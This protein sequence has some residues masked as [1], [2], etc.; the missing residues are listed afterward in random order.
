MNNQE[1]KYNNPVKATFNGIRDLFKK[2]E[3]SGELKSSDRLDNKKVLITGSSSGLG[4]A[5]A[6]ELA[7]RGAEVIM[8]VRS[9]IPEKGEEVKQ[10]SGADKVYMIHVDLSD[11]DS[12]SRLVEEIKKRFKKIDILICNAAV[13]SRKA[14]KTKFGL[15]EMFSVNY[16]AKFF[17]V[18]LLI[19]ENCFNKKNRERPR[20]V[21]VSSESHRNPGAFEWDDFGIFKNY[22]MNK[23]V[24]RYGYYKLLMTTF[25]Q[26]LSRRLNPKQEAE[27]SVFALCPGPVNTNIARETPAIFQPL[28][29][30]VFNL[31]FRSPEKACEPVVY[32]AASGDQE[33]KQNDYFYLMSRKDVDQKASDKENGK[34]LWDLT[35]QL[36]EKHY[37]KYQKSVFSY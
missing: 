16:L 10:A 30:V 3:K 32:M 27:Y 19:G 29:K 2:R 18:N 17:L 35:E 4:L 34:R 21:F 25:S 7:K 13:V 33:G 28:L 20:I 8:A 37:P 14:R 5:T 11:F 22:G 36:L 24:E 9:G 1:K 23:S 6:K 12:I 26:E 15:E 31:F